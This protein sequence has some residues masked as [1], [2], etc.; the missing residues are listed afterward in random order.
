[1]FLR[2]VGTFLSDYTAS[3]PPPKKNKNLHADRREN[4]K[5]QLMTRYLLLFLWD[6][7][8]MLSFE[9]KYFNFIYDTTLT[10]FPI[11][12][13]HTL[14]ISSNIYWTLQL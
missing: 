9:K 4:L 6:N 10:V 8:A 5:S 11:S 7:V 13:G 3:L 2:N 12:N 1:M 14:Y